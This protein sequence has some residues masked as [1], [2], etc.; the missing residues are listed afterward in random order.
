M[1]LILILNWISTLTKTLWNATKFG[2]YLYYLKHNFLFNTILILTF[3]HGI[4]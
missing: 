2:G 4:E 1:I 3:L